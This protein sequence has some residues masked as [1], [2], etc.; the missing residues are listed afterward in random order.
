ML[1]HYWDTHFPYYAPE[2]YV[3]GFQDSIRTKES[4]S[5]RV[6]DLENEIKGPWLQK[7]LEHFD[8][9]CVDHVRARYHASAAYVE[10]QVGRL[11]DFLD[12][13]DILEKT[14]VVITSD[15]GESLGEHGIWFDH[16]GLYEPSIKVPLILY[17]P[18][19][20][21][22]RIKGFIQHVDLLPSLLELLGLN[23]E[24]NVFDGANIFNKIEENV[25]KLELRNFVY[26]EEA[27]TERKF[28]IRVGKYKLIT[29]FKPEDAF[30]RYCSRVHG[31]LEELYNLEKDPLEKQNIIYDEPDI[32]KEL[33]ARVIKLLREI[34]RKKMRMKMASIKLKLSRRVNVGDQN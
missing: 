33:K 29:A 27:Y 5:L 14:I 17:I 32:A 8:N 19:V 22:R 26:A 6:K 1:L 9:E 18:G 10:E 2:S 16:H 11:I 13:N 7:L 24:Y 31:G 21:G 12:E 28:A 4:C 3:E 30:C 15:H 25:D 23:V 34:Q 20:K